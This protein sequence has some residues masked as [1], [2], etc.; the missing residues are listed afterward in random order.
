MADKP[1]GKP[2]TIWIPKD[3]LFTLD[4]LADKCKLS[5]SRL[6]INLLTIGAEEIQAM[7]SCGLLA[8]TRALQRMA[9]KI[10][11]VGESLHSGEVIA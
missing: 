3:L 10:R 9:D 1:E 6:C 7:D 8:L 11:A 2:V 4:E 5:R